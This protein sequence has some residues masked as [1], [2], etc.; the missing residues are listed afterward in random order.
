MIPVGTPLARTFGNEEYEF[1][2]RGHLESGPF[3]DSL[4]RSSL[5]TCAAGER[6]EWSAGFA[7]SES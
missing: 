4:G 6:N 3:A 5:L 2:G 7:Q 1:Y